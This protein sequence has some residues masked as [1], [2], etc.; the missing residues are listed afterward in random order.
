M[1]RKN[2]NAQESLDRIKLMMNYTSS[3][4]LTENI[5][6]ILEE[7]KGDKLFNAIRKFVGGI[8]NKTL[9]DD[10]VKG[11][12]EMADLAKKIQKGTANA[13]ELSEFSRFLLFKNEPRLRTGA[14]KKFFDELVTEY[15]A[16]MKN[17]PN[18]KMFLKSYEKD[19]QNALD[20]LCGSDEV[21]KNKL[22]EEIYKQHNIPYMKTKI[23]SPDDDVLKRKTEPPKQKD[24]TMPKGVARYDENLA[25]IVYNKNKAKIDGLIEESKK[26]SKWNFATWKKRLAQ[27]G[28][29]GL[30]I[31]PLLLFLMEDEKIEP[32]EDIP[33]GSNQAPPTPPT[34]PTAPDQPASGGKGQGTGSSQSG[35]KNSGA[36]SPSKEKLNATKEGNY[37][38][39]TSET[40]D[41]WSYRFNTTTSRWEAK[42]SNQPDRGWIDVNPS[43]ATTD[44]DK[45]RLERAENAIRQ[46]YDS[47]VAPLL[48]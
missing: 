43:G 33:A 26:G 14:N 16:G 11:N 37:I 41:P 22:A 12:D 34:P 27:I 35:G 45:K 4:T 24:G 3:K 13:D 42:N 28:I 15:V 48:K 19:P 7:G 46:R 10:I 36:A 2:Y 32:V 44:A 5:Q 31:I 1:I 17:G 18:G 40:G 23:D 6:E 47:I 8:S 21:L 39:V 29:G 30:I 20:I 25:R 9:I 38:N